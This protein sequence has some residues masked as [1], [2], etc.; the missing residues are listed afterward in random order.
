MSQL[1]YGSAGVTAR[2]IDRSGP[3]A[4]EPVGIPAG[5][6]GTANRGPAFVPVT[7]G[8][9][10]DFYAKFGQTDGKKYGPLAVNE[11]LR[12]AGSVTYMRVLGAGDGKKR[13]EDG[14]VNGAGFTVGEQQPRD[15]DGML[16]SNPYAVSGTDS[17]LG[18]TYFL[19][20]FMS[21]SLG[22]TVFSDSSIQKN[23]TALPII[24]GVLMAPSGV[25]LRM[26]ST[27]VPSAAPG[28]ATVATNV[29][30]QGSLYGTVQLMQGGVAPKQEF[31]L[32]LNG[33][34]G[35]D[36]LYSNVITASFDMT[37]P[38]YFANVLN[39]D[40]LK[41]QQAGHC[42]YSNWDIH[43]AV[44][45]VTGSGIV[46]ASL[47]AGAATNTVTGFET[48]A[49]LTTSSLERN[50]GSDVV[51][52]Y[53]AWT[54]RHSHGMTPWVTSQK[55]G[56][57]VANLFR[58]HALDAGADISSKYKFSIEN[59][60]P[61]TDPANKYGSFDFVIRD[62]GDND[63]NVSYIE[64]RRGLSLDPSSDRY[65]AKV[66]GDANV[67]FNFDQVESG[68][69][70][71]LDGNYPNAS[72]IVR[73]EVSQG[74]D[75]QYV[76][77][78]ALPFGFR[79]PAHLLTSGSAPFASCVIAGITIGTPI[80]AADTLKRA[81]Q[82]PVP[83]RRNITQGSGAKL[84]VNPLLYWGT[85]TEHVTST[86][87]QNAS[88]LFD[89][90]LLAITKF[91]PS[92]SETEQ[93][94]VVGNNA[95][96]PPT[97]AC[98]IIDS[99]KFCNN[100]FSLDNIAVVTSSTGLADPAVWSSAV[101]HRDGSVIVDDVAKVRRLSPDDL[102]QANRRYV[103]FTFMMQ[104]GFDG[105]NVFNRDE[106]EINNAAVTA[107]MNDAN[108]GR[109]SGPA[110]RAYMKALDI[111][112]NVVN[113]DIQLLA[114]PGIR[115][116]VVTNA[117]INAVEERFD[118]MY[119]M[120]VEQ[121]DNNADAVVNDSQLPSVQYTVEAFKDRSLDSSFA[122]AYF[123]DVV[124][125]DPNTGTNV[126]APPSVAVLGALALNDSVGYP[127][128]APAG[129]TR[130]ALSS[131]LEAR[132]KLSKTNLDALYDVSINPLVAFPGNA[133]A[134]TNPHGG[135]VV[136]GQK[137]LQVA[138]SALDRVN[139]RRLLIDIRRQVRDIAQTITFEPNRETTLAK[140]SAAVTP[141]LQRVQALAGL[142]RFK[143]I[144]D[145]STTTQQD[146]ENNV[147]RGKIY[148]QPTKSLEYVS[149]DFIV[150][151]NIQ[152]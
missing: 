31:V 9:I 68:Q 147:V 62:F 38:N 13:N 26:S 59:I 129:F 50:I 7:V 39:R 100:A 125:K 115:H 103:K 32:L 42:L 25:I 24:R 61:S 30:A 57:A 14:S 96:T 3:V 21:E 71:I 86:T 1:K 143:V 142:E 45:T 112:K 119:I 82:P 124:M 95:G 65:I 123:P 111:M 85:R 133:T 132:V 145:S 144:I 6:I 29:T 81:V 56:G 148:V 126:V 48:A 8:L 108:R 40:P 88:A 105:T 5:I 69:K 49:F 89:K 51:P 23:T 113:V 36:D 11:W 66:I 107:D 28:A 92:F 120:D 114:T 138:A 94:F 110:V 152:Q 34:K 97:V 149:L 104:G 91:Y 128:F 58:F 22:S 41:L 101:Y 116:S 75:N 136:W 93:T 46:T 150:S 64:Q 117:A 90:S 10:S 52:N 72:N 74:V 141:R 98:G 63:M 109:Q 70:L 127:W 76:D 102:T 20:A 73:V 19:G 80:V 99:D 16:A 35:T 33:H 2:E 55:F 121:Y 137:T 78:T 18:R 106:R 53:E 37:A 87:T 84:S 146:V 47:G 17:V 79:G 122:A 54:D 135:V 83:M 130:G 77:A 67:F 118:A 151:N 131:T 134:G 15:A 43:P 12:N 140:F 44:A 60:A 139:V 4:R 27:F